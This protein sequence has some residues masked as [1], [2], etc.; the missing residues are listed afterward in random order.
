[1]VER[2]RCAAGVERIKSTRICQMIDGY[3]QCP[4]AARPDDP[5]GFCGT[6]R[7]AANN[8]TR[9]GLRWDGRDA[10]LLWKDCDQS[11]P[12]PNAGAEARW[13]K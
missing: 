5:S 12:N 11:R 3:H 6:H 4:N 2:V 1:M 8:A 13:A 10:V 7:N 9:D